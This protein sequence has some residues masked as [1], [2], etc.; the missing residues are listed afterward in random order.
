MINS[1]GRM[2]PE[3]IMGYKEVIP[4]QSPHNLN[5]PEQKA[6]GYPGKILPGENKLL[7]TIEEAIKKCDLRDGMTI[8]FHHHFRNG[9]YV[10]NMV[11]EQIAKK[12]IKDLKIAASSIFPIHAPLL[13]HIKNGTVSRLSCN[14]MLG[15]VAEA[16]CNGAFE[17]PVIFRTHGGRD[18]AI[19]AGEESID[20]AFIGASAADKAGNFNGT[21]GPSACGS[22]GYSVSDCMYAKKVVVLTDYLVPYPLAPASVEETHVDYV[23]KVDSVGDPAG[24]A[25]GAVR[26]VRDPLGL[27]IAKLASDVIDASGLLKDGI[28]FQ[29]GAGGPTL[30][31]AKFLS[32]K[33]KKRGIVGSFGSGGITSYFVE[34]LQDGLFRYL[35]DTQ[36]FDTVAAKSLK[37][38]PKHIEVS[39]SRYANPHNKGC[40]VNNLDVMIL[41]ATEVDV[42]FNVNVHTT[43]DGI[44]IGGSG[45]N[46][47]TAA[48]SKLAIVVTPAIRGRMPI[49]QEKVLT[50][51][52]PGETVDCIVT[53]MG[54]AVNP[55]RKDLEEK[56]LAMGLPVKNI[57]DLK[58]SIEKLTGKPEK[59][60]TTD[61]VVAVVEYRNGS[62]IDVIRKLSN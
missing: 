59:I 10:L 34:M 1:V 54:I 20:V 37:E 6:P 42:D 55:R 30:A 41:G 7:P 60:K 13:E 44:V 36:C 61:E 23:I 28:S 38:N 17:Y 4:Y 25:T 49:I 16:M 5:P 33:M 52:T 3:Q 9:D 22:L 47:D 29:T 2:I 24:I 53:D 62:V 19:E 40:I 35:L 32:E 46:A 51:T 14:Y 8:S 15:P 48:C 50:L 21:E 26:M 39:S 58:N 11:L 18:R 12:G 57:Y 43:S 56:L 31:V 45:G 27:Y